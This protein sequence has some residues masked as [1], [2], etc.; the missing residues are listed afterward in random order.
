[1]FKRI[2]TL[3]MIAALSLA[4]LFAV[5]CIVGWFLPVE[6]KLSVIQTALVKFES[7]LARS[8]SDW[9]LAINIFL[10]NL[11][12]AVIVLV[13]SVIPLVT[14]GIIFANGLLIGMFG[15]LLWRLN[16][17]QPS[18][19]KSAVVSLV[20]HG[21]F[22]LSAIFLAGSLG[23]VLFIK[24]VIPGRIQPSATRGQFFITTL[25]CFG[26]VVIP[27]LM[28]AGVVET[29]I[30]P[31]VAEMV[32]NDTNAA[33]DSPYVVKLEP[34]AL[35]E[36]DCI[37]GAASSLASVTSDQLSLLYAPEVTTLLQRR[38]A[39]PQW[40]TTYNC[41]QGGWFSVASFAAD[42][43]SADQAY[44][45]IVVMLEHLQANYT[46][47]TTQTIDTKINAVKLHYTVLALPGRT[48]VVTQTDL[49]FK[50]QDL[51]VVDTTQ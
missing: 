30:S 48:V 3:W 42:Q 5:G 16:Y 38:S 46:L 37:P 41:P 36:T 19:F 50:P 51:L 33:V 20:P 17:I 12:V 27:L 11:L 47:P 40:Q 6:I 7:I 4:T 31:R 39:V 9:L 14:L 21:I 1:M 35:A 28:I 2:G 34:L 22:E 44:Q 29:F 8:S 45:L 26:F 32:L 23:L 49:P 13:A 10:N 15:D 25:Q 18:T 43:W 24:L